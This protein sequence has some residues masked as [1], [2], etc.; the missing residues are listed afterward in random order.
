M[1]YKDGKTKIDGYRKQIKTLREEMR[2]AQ[3][4]L[5]PQVVEDYA[6]ATTSGPVKLSD[7]FGDKKG[8]HRHSQH[9]RVLPVLHALGGRLQRGRRTFGRPRGLRGREPRR[10]GGAEEIRQIGRAHV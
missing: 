7:L 10:A 4:E 1:K 9:G 3:N 6:L 5:E 8:S 2:A